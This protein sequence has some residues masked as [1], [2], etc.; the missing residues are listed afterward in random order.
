MKKN[1]TYVLMMLLFVIN[2]QLV[3]KTNTNYRLKYLHY[4]NSS[5][6]KGK[7]T[8]FYSQEN[9][10]YKAKW[11]LMNGSRSSINYHFFNESGNIIRKYREF[12]DSITSNNFYKYDSNGNLIEDYFERSDKVKGIVWYKYKE[13]KKV[14]AECRGLNAWFFGNI[15]YKY[16]NDVLTKGL[17]FK[18]GKQIGFIEYI[19]NDEGNLITEH[20]DFNGKWTQTF[21]FEYEEVKNKLP[22][23]YSYSSPFLNETKEFIVNEEDYDWNGEKGGPSIYEYKRNKLI[24]KVY[25]YD[26]LETITRYEYDDDGLLMKSFRNYSDGR[27]AEFSYHF[28]KDR[29]LV[30]RLFHGDYGFRGSESYKYDQKGRLIEAKLNKFDS[31]LSGI[32]TF[33]YG[34]N[35]ELKSGVFNGEDNFD[36]DMIFELDNYGNLTKIHWDFSFGKTQTYSFRYDKL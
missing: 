21:T 32:I 29:Q 5:G 14:E 24:K 35:N 9:K 30:R 11:E 34:T 31:W 17:I 26:S 12:S 18:E 1:K 10:N 16:K 13:G 20:W 4:E 28:N 8:L 36:A 19:Y 22:E 3:A 23:Y 25:K 2:I 33:E 15:K 27:K 6:E 7:T